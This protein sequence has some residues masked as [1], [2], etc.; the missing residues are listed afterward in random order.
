MSRLQST[1]LFA[2]AALLIGCSSSGEFKP[3]GKDTGADPRTQLAA[4]SASADSPAYGVIWLS[5]SVSIHCV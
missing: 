4:Y 3:V 2:A 5:N 1:A